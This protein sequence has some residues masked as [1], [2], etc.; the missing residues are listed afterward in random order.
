MDAELES[1]SIEDRFVEF[2]KDVY[3]DE[4]G[5]VVSKG[6]D[7]LVVE[8][9]D[10]QKFDTELAD[11]LV[12]N[13]EEIIEKGE[14]ALNSIPLSG[15]DSLNLRFR[16]LPD[17]EVVEIRNLRSKHLEIHINSWTC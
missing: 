3:E 1:E 4:I 7:S 15:E 14:E 2:L 13:P 16:D 10:L 5:Q 6:S 8:F 12:N 11:R 17:T 9:K